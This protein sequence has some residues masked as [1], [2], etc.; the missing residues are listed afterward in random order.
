VDAAAVS[1]ISATL[2][3]QFQLTSSR[4]ASD[5]VQ[6]ALVSLGAKHFSCLAQEIS[7]RRLALDTFNRSMVWLRMTLTCPD[8]S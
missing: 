4:K 6:E 3:L 2:L 5:I 7:G 8:P 1:M